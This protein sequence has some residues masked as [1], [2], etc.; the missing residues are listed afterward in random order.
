MLENGHFVEMWKLCMMGVSIV[1]FAS[2]V[3]FL[4]FDR[5]FYIYKCQHCQQE[6]DELNAKLNRAKH[7]KN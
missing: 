1:F 6:L 3:L 5:W 2:T 4:V 7:E